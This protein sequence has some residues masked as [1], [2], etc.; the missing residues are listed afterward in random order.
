MRVELKIDSGCREP[1][2]ELH[3]ARLTPGLQT[4]LLYTSRCV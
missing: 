2:A 1:Y 3:V 4:C